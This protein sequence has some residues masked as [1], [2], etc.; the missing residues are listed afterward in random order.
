M[1]ENNP[2]VSLADPFPVTDET[3]F[4]QEDRIKLFVTDGFR[5]ASRMV[6]SAVRHE[7]SA[8]ATEP[9]HLLIDR[10]TYGLATAS[11]TCRERLVILFRDSRPT[12]QDLLFE[13]GPK[14]SLNSG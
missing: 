3:H 2:F 11:T 1:R 13:L 14:M 8:S 9:D 4:E 7:Q 6:L 10:C 5:R 12:P